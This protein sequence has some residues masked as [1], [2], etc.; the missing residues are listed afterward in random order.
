MPFENDAVVRAYAGKIN[1]HKMGMGVDI[2]IKMTLDIFKFETVQLLNSALQNAHAQIS[3]RIFLQDINDLIR[4]LYAINAETFKNY[5]TR[6]EAMITNEEINFVK[7]ATLIERMLKASETA[8]N[9]PLQCVPNLL[10]SLVKQVLKQLPKTESINRADEFD[11]AFKMISLLAGIIYRIDVAQCKS[12]TTGLAEAV[13]KCEIT[14]NQI[15]VLIERLLDEEY[16]EKFSHDQNNTYLRSLN[17]ITDLLITII[18]EEDRAAFILIIHDPLYSFEKLI[19][20]IDLVRSAERD[21]KFSIAKEKCAIIEGKNPQLDSLVK[22][23]VVHLQELLD[24]L[25]NTTAAKLPPVIKM[26]CQILA[27]NLNNKLSTVENREQIITLYICSFISNKL[28]GDLI[29]KW[30]SK[31]FSGDLEFLNAVAYFIIKP[32]QTLVTYLNMNEKNK[33]EKPLDFPERIKQLINSDNQQKLIGMAQRILEE[34]P[35]ALRQ[36][37]QVAITPFV[38]N[39][40]FLLSAVPPLSIGSG[41]QSN[42]K[43]GSDAADLG[44][45]KATVEPIAH[46]QPAASTPSLAV[47]STLAIAP[48]KPSAV[49]A[50][51]GEKKY[52]DKEID[53]QELILR[54]QI[55]Y[56]DCLALAVQLNV[57]TLLPSQKTGTIKVL[58]SIVATPHEK[59]IPSAKKILADIEF[60]TPTLAQNK[61]PDKTK[62]LEMYH[63]LQT[64]I[65]S[66]EGFKA[67]THVDEKADRKIAGKSDNAPPATSQP[68]Q[69][70]LSVGQNGQT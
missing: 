35:P 55:Y 17:I 49:L 45:Q 24:K 9:L 52:L 51:V 41:V 32:I 48:A 42:A 38:S 36:L 56:A 16:K 68:G 3:G 43:S 5:F 4:V 65:V 33:A 26:I 59:V 57:T 14:Y 8:S 6:L 18:P 40:D 62:L 61:T 25:N 34:N 60:L 63:N 70:R 58:S 69:R 37:A 39:V 11:A 2:L 12:F 64:A 7:V 50:V 13:H 23:I 30:V 28:F 22:D 20:R 31:T 53:E 19:S 1:S 54:L 46:A 10:L 47:V 27:N 21:K 29:T 44:K 67:V 15:V 66:Y